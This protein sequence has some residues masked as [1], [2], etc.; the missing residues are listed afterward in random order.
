MDLKSLNGCDCWFGFSR[1]CCKRTWYQHKPACVLRTPSR[2]SNLQPTQ[3]GNELHESN[4]RHTAGSFQAV[5]SPSTCSAQVYQRCTHSYAALV[6]TPYIAHC[7]PMEVNA[8]N[9]VNQVQGR[10]YSVRKRWAQSTTKI[11]DELRA[12]QS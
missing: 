3:T 11:R 1:S 5:L 2:L 10:I 7:L 4:Q 6:I 8:R 12:E 9:H